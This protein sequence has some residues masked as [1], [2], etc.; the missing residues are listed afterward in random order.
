ML[1]R[2]VII[3]RM[4]QCIFQCR[5]AI[6]SQ[7]NDRRQCYPLFCSY[8]M[9]YMAAL[10]SICRRELSTLR[11]SFSLAFL[12]F[13]LRGVNSTQY[14]AQ[15]SWLEIWIWTKQCEGTASKN[16]RT[17]DL[18]A[19]SEVPQTTASPRAQPIHD[20]INTF[21]SLKPTCTPAGPLIV[22][23]VCSPVHARKFQINGARFHCIS[24]NVTLFLYLLTLEYGPDRLSQNFGRKLAVLRMRGVTSQKSA[25]I[26]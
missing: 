22:W 26:I 14:T 23:A 9:E 17:R 20:R 15:R 13:L 19:C 6:G 24:Y 18:P 12:L 1:L 2:Y 21:S 7:L 3:D 8:R 4:S 5:S 11:W 16:N 10:A 25:H